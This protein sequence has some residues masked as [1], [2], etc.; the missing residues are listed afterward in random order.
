MNKLRVWCV[1]IVVLLFGALVSCNPISNEPSTPQA[2]A[3]V[4]KVNKDSYFSFSDV[5]GVLLIPTN[6][7]LVKGSMA[8]I[9]CTV[10]DPHNIGTG[11]LSINLLGTPEV[12][13]SP[14][15]LVAKQGDDNDVVAN[16]A[17]YE[18][19]A[20]KNAGEFK[21]ALFDSETLLI[22]L[23]YF[24]K[25]T[26]AAEVSA[27]LKLHSFNLVC[28][29]DEIVAGDT[30]LN[31]YLR[32]VVADDVSVARIK[33][34]WQYKSYSLT[35]ALEQFKTKSGS[36]KPESLVIHYDQNMQTDELKPDNAGAQKWEFPY[37]PQPQMLGRVR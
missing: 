12:L 27:E 7:T 20:P 17:I 15:H 19:K 26:G 36:E 13:D 6:P 24:I 9:G 28:Y 11:K 30:K 33:G 3:G 35:E 34:V 4:V 16:T 32:H 18:L 2:W 25:Y 8:Y 23:Q 10:N 37:N 21:P 22:P 5:E 14:S 29:T 1:G 31:L